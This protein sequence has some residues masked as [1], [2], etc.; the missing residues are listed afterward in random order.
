VF[1]W[2]GGSSEMTATSHY[3]KLSQSACKQAS[4]DRLWCGSCH[5]PRSTA[6]GGTSGVFRSRCLSCHQSSACKESMP[7]RRNASDDCAGCHMLR[8]RRRTWN[9][10]RLRTTPFRAG[11]GP[12]PRR[13]CA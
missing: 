7:V 10:S 3:E 9:T 8:A 4:G 11:R 6:T 1:V 13:G 12:L 5:D 2:S